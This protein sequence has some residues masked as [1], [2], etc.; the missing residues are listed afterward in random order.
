MIS[1]MYYNNGL[2]NLPTTKRLS[3]FLDPSRAGADE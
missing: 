3:Y 1:I 2:H